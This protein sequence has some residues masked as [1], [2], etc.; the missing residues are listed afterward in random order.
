MSGASELTNE[1]KAWQDNYI[2]AVKKLDKAEN[3]LLSG[4]K[5]EACNLQKEAS[6]DG[7]KAIEALILINYKFNRDIDIA[8]L[9]TQ[10]Q[11]WQLLEEC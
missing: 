3:L 10:V 9:D 4:K 2:N 11:K 7:V 8:Y 1:L 6:T 5:T